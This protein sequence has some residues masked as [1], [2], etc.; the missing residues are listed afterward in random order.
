MGG[1]NG[2]RLSNMLIPGFQP[3][4]RTLNLR[5]TQCELECSNF[6]IVFANEYFPYQ[7]FFNMKALI[8]YGKVIEWEFPDLM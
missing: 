5:N 3:K 7:K 8:Y 1:E 2:Y 4:Y 6:E